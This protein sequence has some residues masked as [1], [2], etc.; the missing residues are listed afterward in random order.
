MR[1]GVIA[2]SAKKKRNRPKRSV[3]LLRWYA[4]G[5]LIFYVLPLLLGLPELAGV[6]AFLQGIPVLPE[7]IQLLAGKPALAAVAKLLAHLFSPAGAGIILVVLAVIGLSKLLSTHSGWSR[8]AGRLRNKSRRLAQETRVRPLDEP[9]DCFL[10]VVRMD[11]CDESLLQLT[12][13]VRAILPLEDKSVWQAVL[14]DKCVHIFQGAELFKVLN[15][16]EPFY[17]EPCS[18]YIQFL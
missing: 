3:H 14:H 10:R 7:L 5:F 8:A 17:L 18:S 4:A 2:M 11:S 1:K 6:L 15:D 16:H 9:R 13:G 12:Y